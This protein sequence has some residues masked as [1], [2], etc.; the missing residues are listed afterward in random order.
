MEKFAGG[1]SLQ[2][3]MVAAVGEMFGENVAICIRYSLRTE[4]KG[5]DARLLRLNK[6]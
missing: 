1:R 4:E 6:V 2:I 3:V 5:D